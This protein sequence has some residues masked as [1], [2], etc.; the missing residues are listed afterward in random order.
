V[1]PITIINKKKALLREFQII[2]GTSLDSV[3]SVNVEFLKQKLGVDEENLRIL[4]KEIS[5]KLK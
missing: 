3:S 2:F 5:E 4:W 1:R